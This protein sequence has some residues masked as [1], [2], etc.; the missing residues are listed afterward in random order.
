M[1]EVAWLIEAPGRRYLAARKLSGYQFHWTTDH[2][3]ALRFCKED[4]AD[5]AMMAL[6]ELDPSLFEFERT[7]GNATPIEHAWVD[8]PPPSTTGHEAGTQE[9]AA[10]VP[11]AEQKEMKG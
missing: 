2:L 8:A 6:R 5:L 7:L 9:K 4:Q 1:N 11:G 10:E 3:K